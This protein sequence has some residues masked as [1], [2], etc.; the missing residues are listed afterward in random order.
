MKFYAIYTL[1]K[2]IFLDDGLSSFLSV[3]DSFPCKAVSGLV[4]ERGSGI[5]HTKNR[6]TLGIL[7]TYDLEY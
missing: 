1:L 2:C 7:L 5:F 3:L 6:L 4:T